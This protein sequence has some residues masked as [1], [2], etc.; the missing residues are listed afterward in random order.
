MIKTITLQKKQLI[1][2][3]IKDFRSSKNITW[4]DVLNPS[5]KEINEISEITR[6]PIDEIEMALDEDERPRIVELYN[7]ALLIVRV[8]YK[9]HKETL[10]TSLSIFFSEHNIIT[11]HKHKIESIEKI[12]DF[13]EKIKKDMLKDTTYFLYRLLAEITNNYF[14]L[15]DNV[16]EK[17]DY[18][19]NKVFHSPENRTVKEIFEIKKMLIY[20]HKAF[21]SDREIL[22]ELEKGYISSIKKT[23]MRQFRY[24]YNDLTQ[25]IDMGGTYRDV[26]TGVLDLYLSSTSHSLNI[27]MKK[28]TAYASLILVPTLISGIYGMNFRWMPELYWKYGYFF[29]L[30]LMVFFVVIMYIYFKKKDWI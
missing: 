6:F 27:I 29:A 2:S 25:L 5:E 8:P 28:M 16:E 9:D 15:M 18:L 7:H 3:S 13:S 23:Y 12:N 20:F 30:G 1:K 10:T 19:E 21:A 22:V 11:M 14:R 4:I 24:V 26:I 17:I